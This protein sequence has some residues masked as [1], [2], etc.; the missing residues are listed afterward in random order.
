[1]KY[2]VALK[3]SGSVRAV[4]RLDLGI[5]HR[6]SCPDLEPWSGLGLSVQSSRPPWRRL[7]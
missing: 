6:L 2:K 4:T 1:M 7:R 3:K 5:V